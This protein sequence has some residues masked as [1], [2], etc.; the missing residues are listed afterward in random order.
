MG[1][2]THEMKLIRFGEIGKEKPGV[3]VGDGVRLDVSAF[4]SDYGEN[5]FA[6][7]GVSN[8]ER[9]L[10]E[11]PSLAPTIDGDLRLGCPI[12]RPSKI[13]CVGLNFRDHAVESGMQ[14][15]NEPVLFFKSTTA[16]AGP[17]DNLVI[18]RN[19]QKVDWEVELAVVIGQRASYISRENAREF[20]A[21]Y[22]LHNDYSERS[23]QLERGGQ[24]V[25]GKSADTFAPLG[26]FLATRDEIP[27]TSNLEMWLT[28]NSEFRQKS[29]TAQMIFDVAAIVS[30]CS[31]F[32]TLLPGD[33]ISTGTPAGVGLGMK[34]PT[35]LKP[36]DVVELG[37]EGLGKSRQSV[38][39][40]TV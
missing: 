36:G 6:E 8:L 24:W 10:T 22:V 14:I 19:A 4:C 30:Y 27:D 26:P 13:V 32:M 12:C 9:W 16:L 15:P 31:E 37:I 11:N 39:A 35:Y 38:V 1:I 25:K 18:P 2:G 33:V 23:F 40:L 3:I 34:P 21:G 20:I 17:N 29:T 5:F 28:V 7:S